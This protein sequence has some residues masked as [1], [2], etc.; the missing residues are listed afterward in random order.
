MYIS[1]HFSYQKGTY[2]T[3]CRDSEQMGVMLTRRKERENKKKR[4]HVIR[5]IGRID[6]VEPR[7]HAYDNESFF[8]FNLM[9]L[10]LP[11]LAS[12]SRK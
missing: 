2:F 1:F 9:D 8:F 12:S 7:K 4:G 11:L 6:K 10:A 3:L 5:E